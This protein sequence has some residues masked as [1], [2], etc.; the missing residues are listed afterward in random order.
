[1]R[2]G[3]TLSALA[4]T[5]FPL[6]AC[7]KVSDLAQPSC[8]YGVTPQ[9]AT[10]SPSG[11]QGTLTVTAPGVCAWSVAAESSWIDFPGPTSGTGSGTVGFTVGTNPLPAPRTANVTVADQAVQVT[12]A[13]ASCTYNVEPGSLSLDAEGETESV[14]VTTDGGCPWTASTEAGWLAIDAGASGTGS[15]RVDVRAE[16]NS[17]ERQRTGTVDI[18]GR[19]ILVTQRTVSPVPGAVPPPTPAPAPDPTPSPNPNPP[20][21]PEPNPAPPP[22]PP[23]PPACEYTAAPTA[24]SFESA[25]GTGVVEVGTTSA[26]TWTAA[27]GASWIVVT[28]SGTRTGPGSIGFVVA[29]NVSTASRTGALTV[30]GITISVTQTGV[31]C[32][33]T[34]TP[35]S[36]SF[37]TESGTGEIGVG[38]LPGCT[39]TAVSD[40]GW[41]V[42]A[43]TS[44]TGTGEGTIQYSVARNRSQN[45]R[46]ATLTV[47]GMA[48]ATITQAG[49]RDE[50]DDD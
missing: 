40:A 36:A 38:T 48:T 26:C 11:G 5:A 25:G 6:L 10:F 18:A 3:P 44:G 20:P 21:L 7:T 27:S 45:A 43:P 28:S 13:P 15:G 50:E 34:V 42:V 39:W 24:P 22:A 49:E 37:T 33:Y 1:M 47:G 9:P 46:T 8:T 32:V 35:T 23:P 2:V 29:P 41:L 4:L 12:Q 31:A 30:A 17:L 19:R 16:P 14:F